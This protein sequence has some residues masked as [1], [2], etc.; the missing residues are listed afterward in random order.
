LCRDPSP[1]SELQVAQPAPNPLP[2]PGI[3][4]VYEGGEQIRINTLVNGARFTLKRG[5]TPLGTWRTWGYAHLVGLTPPYSA[6]EIL[7]VTQAL[8]PGNPPSPPGSTTVRPCSAL[9]AP[10]VAPVQDGDTSITLLDFVPDAR[11]KVFVNGVKTGDGGGS[12]IM[13]SSPVPHG[14]TIHV[15]QTLG[16]CVGS[17]V[18]ETHVQCVAPPVAANPAALDL[19]PVGHKAY[20][21]S[22]LTFLG[23][24][25][26]VKGTVYYPAQSDGEGTP[27]NERLAGLGRVPIVFMAHGNHGRFH[28]PVNRNIESCSN[29]GGWVEIPNHEGYDYFQRQL[30]RMGII[31]V[32][33]Y[34]NQAN[35]RDFSITTI[36][37]RAELI[38]ASI[39]RFQD[40]DS[41]VDPIFVGRIDFARVGLMGHSQG[42][43]A[44]VVVPEISPPFQRA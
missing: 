6:G 10:V 30:A 11:I 34:S 43:E 13:L 1:P 44:V 36:R 29:P 24:T 2:T 42:G 14:A 23:E 9:P 19:F 7:E 8:C 12:V 25:L 27:F 35:C 32:S 5:G 3:D 20:D 22:T 41:G 15:L 33:V 4:P 31:A 40:F 18:W 38:L 26:N 28:D 37:R 17:T 21:T 16:S 39:Q